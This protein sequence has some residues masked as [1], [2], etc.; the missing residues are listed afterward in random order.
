MANIR[1]IEVG[2]G[3]LSY[4][5]DIV[6]GVPKID[7]F[8]S[9]VSAIG[10]EGDLSGGLNKRN[11]VIVD[12][13]N[14]KYEV[15]PDAYL[16]NDRTSSRTLNN[17][18][19][20]TAQY[21]A[22]FRGALVYM[23]T[24]N[25]DLLVLSLPV[26][27]MQRS[28]ELKA[29]ALG[30]HCINGKNINVK[31]V[32]IL[33]QPLAG[34]LAYANQIGHERFNELSQSNVLCL[35]FGFTTSDWLMTRGLKI[36]YKKSGARNMGMSTVLESCAA[37]L[38]VKGA[39]EYLD[40]LPRTLIDEAFYRHEGVIKISGK[41]YPFP[42]CNY[43]DI[44]HNQ[45]NIAFDCAPAIKQISYSS[46]QEVRNNVGAG[47]DVSLIVVMGGAHQVYLDA[48]KD[49]YPHHE[50]VIVDNPIVAVCFGMY[51]GGLQYFEA[52]QS[53]KEVA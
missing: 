15:G 51:F 42:T 49:N 50:I 28:E 30:N 47:S 40:D 29:F 44:N 14:E 25:I 26:N 10:N 53:T 41:S 43:E 1:A 45:V 4:T 6:N 37:A 7:T 19:I 34:F 8:P 24:E 38:K 48:V 17:R 23:N 27:N 16:L 21:R 18:Y 46:L 33:C 52:I 9:I 5:K 3:T 20:D 31:H 13:G 22:L 12:V 2:Y 11:T 39:F 32:W 35:D 36:N